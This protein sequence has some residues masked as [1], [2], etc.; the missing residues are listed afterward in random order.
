MKMSNLLGIS[1]FY[2]IDVFELFPEK[3]RTLS[4]PHQADYSITNATNL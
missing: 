3:F 2:T 1:A 4:E